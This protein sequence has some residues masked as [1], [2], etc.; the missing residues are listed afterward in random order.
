MSTF[1]DCYK[2][3]KPNLRFYSFFSRTD[4]RFYSFSLDT[5]LIEKDGGVVPIEVKA[6]NTSTVSLNNFIIDY[7]PPIAYKFINGNVGRVDNKI[8]L[9]HY[10]VMFV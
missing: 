8:T 10:M 5:F 6:G 3:D 7:N 1:L 2:S 4:L 9:P